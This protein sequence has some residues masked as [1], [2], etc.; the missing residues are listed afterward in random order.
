MALENTR[1]VCE[2]TYIHFIEEQLQ[3]A[4]S[5]IDVIEI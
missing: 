1:E 4:A 5:Q 2:K 3:E